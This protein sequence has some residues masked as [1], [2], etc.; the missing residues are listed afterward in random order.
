MSAVQLLM[1]AAL[2]CPDF[3][4]ADALDPNAFKADVSRSSVTTMPAFTVDEAASAKTHT[5]FMGADIAINLDRDIYKVQD[6]LGSNWVININGREK[7]ISAR[8]A[9]LN[10]KITP[11]LKLT[12]VSATVVGFKRV[13]AYSYANDPSVRLT[14]GLDST[15]SM[16]NDL[17]ARAQ[18]AQIIVDTMTNKA[19]GGAGLLAGTWDQFSANAM[20]ITAQHAYSNLHTTGVTPGTGVG[21]G[22][23]LPSSV[24]GGGGDALGLGAVS[25][26]PNIRAAEV[27]AA[28]IIGQSANGNEPGRIASR[29]L[30][31]LDIEFD[32]RSS[33]PLHNPYIVTMTRFRTASSRPGMVQNM[34]YAESLHPIDE[35]LS[36]VHFVEEGFPFDYEL[37]DFQVHIY[38]RGEEVATN[39]A[40][41]RVELTRDEA[42]E[43]VK[44]EYVGAH[45]KDTLPA[46]PVMGKL[47]ADL[48]AKLGQ[49]KYA[50]VY[51]VRVSKEGLAFTA[52]SDPACTKE[53]D[54]PYLTS[55]IKRIRFKPALNNGKTVDS[56]APL[57]LGQLS[58]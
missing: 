2:S 13:A 37:V 5:L 9:P 27:S 26:D 34:V 18:N 49:G 33:K 46:V 16:N 10:L 28:S 38:N 57:R 3:V 31:A 7:E 48:P 50:G 43:Y 30:D 32:I 56:I 47:P 19:M 52:Y 25:A 20:E 29:G 15:A 39:I 17:M 11:T 8:Q 40:A 22:L 53:I 51:Y 55:V 1:L 21:S 14:K 23:P 44:M 42:F 54:D 12:E 36:H 6:V 35:H 45:P 24:V 58:I 41:D 4:R